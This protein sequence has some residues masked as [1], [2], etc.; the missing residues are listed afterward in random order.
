MQTHAQSM[1]LA[2]FAADSL[3]LGT[4]WIYDTTIINQRFG[5]ITSLLA[6]HE[7]S[8]HPIKT[9]GDFTHYGDQS[10]HLLEHLTKRRG[11]FDVAEY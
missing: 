8:Y 2:S 4:H 10:F 5:R 3:A 7:G 1:M 11:H 6:P 9:R